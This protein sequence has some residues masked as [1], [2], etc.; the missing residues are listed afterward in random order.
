MGGLSCNHAQSSMNMVNVFVVEYLN[1]EYFLGWVVQLVHCII[2]F[3]LSRSTPPL[4]G[5]THE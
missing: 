1:C 5:S 3:V 4:Y 2:I